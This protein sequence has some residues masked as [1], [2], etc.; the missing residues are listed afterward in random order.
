MII[1]TFWVARAQ[2]LTILLADSALHLLISQSTDSALSRYLL[3]VFGN[4]HV[5]KSVHK[6]FGQLQVP[7]G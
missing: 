7:T 2:R 1:V 3:A 4:A 5:S 6:C